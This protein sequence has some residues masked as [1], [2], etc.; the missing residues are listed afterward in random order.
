M[1]AEIDHHDQV[2]RV[3]FVDPVT[4]QQREVTTLGKVSSRREATSRLRQA[5][6]GVLG[7]WRDGESGPVRTVEGDGRTR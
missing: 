3:L 1:F 5:N 4:H 6:Y 2:L 7:R